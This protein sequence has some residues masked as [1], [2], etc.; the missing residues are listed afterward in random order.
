MNL[1]QRCLLPIVGIF[2]HL[3]I[4]AQTFIY[5]GRVVDDKDVPMET[6]SVSFLREN[7]S[8]CQF[9]ITDADGKFQI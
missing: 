2:C 6:V 5:E 1:F 3:T 4:F 7:K 8:I 9:A